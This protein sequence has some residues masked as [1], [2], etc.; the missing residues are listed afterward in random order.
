[1]GTRLDAGFKTNRWE[2]WRPSVSLCQQDDLIID[3]FELLR[4][5]RDRGLGDVLARDIDQISPE[6]EVN[7]Q[8]ITFEDPWDF[9]QVF[10]TLHDF[11]RSYPFDT[12]SEDYLVH[13]STGSHV[14]Q[15][16]LFLLTESRHFPARMVQTAPKIGSNLGTTG[17][18]HRII[19]L[20]LSRYDRIAARFQ[21]EQRDRISILKSGINTRN[22]S[23][24]QMIDRI[25]TVSISSTAPILLTGPTGSGKSQLAGRIYAVKKERRLVEGPLVE[26]NCATMRGDA[27]MSA[28][29]GH[30][31]GSFTGALRDRA[32]LIKRAN[33]GLL[34]L[35]E[36]GEL[37]L[38][39][40]AML[41][42]AI[43]TGNFLPV[44]ADIEDHSSFQLIAGTNRDLA[45][46][47]VAGAFRAD[48]LSRINLWH[49]RLPG[50]AER[51]EDIPPNLDYELEQFTVKTGRRVTFSRE[52]REQF[53]SFAVSPEAIWSGN[54]R[55][56]SGAIQRMSTLAP[57]GR[58]STEEVAEELVRLRLDWGSTTT[59][60]TTAN[61]SAVLTPEQIDNLDRFDRTQL[62]DVI[63]ICGQS[64]S[65]SAAGRALFAASRKRRKTVNDADRL[66]K[67]LTKFDLT[68]QQIK[69]ASR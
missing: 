47:V 32:G 26:I 59:D 22:I 4:E 24:N 62:A 3:R 11:A 14:A 48:L 5:H 29:F 60:P 63:G 28:L 1:M 7:Q 57:G 51:P 43:E 56:L 10:A 69:A 65:I 42:R 16:C 68:F 8:S 31:R 15:I 23:F 2:R 52:A 6:T 30:R 34:F 27:A 45:A 25:N 58:I 66:R 67:Y 41:L 44:G 9:E 20:D 55:D 17:G 54:F 49:F 38:D 64:D 33:G 35:D 19:D 37:G 13:I 18:V 36:I 46:Q 53:L 40:Q 12:D 61:L 50:L 21:Q 39:E